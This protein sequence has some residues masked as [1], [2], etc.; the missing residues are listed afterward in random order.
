MPFTRTKID[1]VIV[2]AG[3]T[4]RGPHDYQCGYEYPLEYI[5]DVGNPEG[6]AAVLATYEFV[7]KW[8]VPR[9]LNLL[10]IDVLDDNRLVLDCQ[11]RDDVTSERIPIVITVL[12]SS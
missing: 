6:T 1:A 10:T 4:V 2:G 9:T 12:V 3:G 8:Y 5:I 11:S 7:P